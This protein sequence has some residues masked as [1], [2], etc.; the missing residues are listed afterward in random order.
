MERGGGFEFVDAIVGGVVPRNF[1][2]AVEKGLVE[3]MEKGAIAGYPAVD[4]RMTLYDG[5]YHNVDSSEMAFKIAASQAFK[6]GVDTARPVLL[7]PVFE[8][9]VEVPVDYMGDIMGDLS[10]KRGRIRS[11]EQ[12]GKN[13]VIVAEVPLEEIQNYSADLNSIT[14]GKGAFAR[15]FS[16]YSEVPGDKAQKIIEAR[17]VDEEES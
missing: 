8:L 7:E 5:S 16:H 10:S 14:A 3:A 1:I 13:A 12:R 11:S 17:K 9:A 2:P 15:A 6:K 4:M